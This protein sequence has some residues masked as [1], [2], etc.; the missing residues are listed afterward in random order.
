[1]QHFNVLGRSTQAVA[2]VAYVQATKELLVQLPSFSNKIGLVKG[3]I[4]E[5]E[6][7]LD[8][9]ER[10]LYEETGISLDLAAMHSEHL[11]R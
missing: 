8:A 11:L 1:M 2:V 5:G 7:C 10:E 3:K 9:A 6:T 4:E